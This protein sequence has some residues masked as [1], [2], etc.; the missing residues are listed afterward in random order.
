M[1]K[2]LIIIGLIIALIYL[3]YQQKTLKANRKEEELIRDLQTQLSQAQA[4]ERF[5][6]QQIERLQQ[7]LEVYSRGED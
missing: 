7:Q 6:G 1:T 5:N 4:L 3:Y 2:E